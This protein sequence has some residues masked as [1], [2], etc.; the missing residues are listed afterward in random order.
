MLINLSNH[1][2]EKWSQQQ[3]TESQKLFGNVEDVAF[4][5]VPPQWDSPDVLKLAGETV[6]DITKQYSDFSVLIAGEQ[7]FL[8]AAVQLFQQQ[9]IDAYCATSERI[10]SQNHDGSKNIVFEFVRFRKIIVP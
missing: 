9:G 7:S 5:N 6:Q 8:V 3:I 2:Y 4:P 1:P 10:V